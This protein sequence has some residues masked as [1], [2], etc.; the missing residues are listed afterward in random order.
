MWD[1]LYVHM[2]GGLIWDFGAARTPR[3]GGKVPAV[4]DEDKQGCD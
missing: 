1:G 2:D 3:I 4:C